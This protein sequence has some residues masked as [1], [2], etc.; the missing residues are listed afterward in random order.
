MAWENF[1][2]EY[3]YLQLIHKVLGGATIP[4]GKE[5]RVSFAFKNEHGDSWT[6]Y[7]AQAS[8][9][10]LTGSLVSYGSSEA[11]A[12]TNYWNVTL[13]NGKFLATLPNIFLAKYARMYVE[14]GEGVSIH[15][16]RSAQYFMADEI[17]T[18]ELL[19]SNLLA[20][21]APLITVEKDGNV[22]IQIGNFT[23]SRYGLVGYDD[24]SNVI[25]ELSDNQ[26]I[27]SGWALGRYTFT[28]DS[29]EVGL[30]SEV[31]GGTDWRFWAGHATP[32]SAPFR[33]DSAGNLYATQANI[34]GTIIAGEIHIPNV[35]VTASSFHVDNDGDTWWGCT[36]S[37]FQSDVNNA[38]AYILKSGAAKFQ[39]IILQGSVGIGYTN[40]DSFTINYD[41]DDIDASL[42]INRTTG[43]S[44]HL[45]WNGSLAQLNRPFKP[46]DLII[47]QISAS[48]PGTTFAGLVW[49]DPSS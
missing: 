26:R 23:G 33:V 41:G 46:T 20:S 15:E 24:S 10:L 18:G 12:Q 4:S 11:N 49:L 1:Q 39:N 6:H 44:M 29:G 36:E 28:S 42:I 32:G 17:V 38:V 45:T 35:D 2:H 13:R 16:W 37:D 48:E 25:F 43:G 22:K 34:T 8:H 14:T 31:S 27:I 40:T 30:N 47:N 7:G 3:P 19:I 21:A 9:E 5:L